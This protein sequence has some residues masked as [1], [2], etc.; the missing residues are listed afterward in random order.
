[1]QRE[2][3][4]EKNWEMSLLDKPLAVC[5]VKNEDGLLEELTL[6]VVSCGSCNF[7]NSRKANRNP[8]VRKKSSLVFTL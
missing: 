2:K 4:Y 7:P 1:M 3:I 6:C 8:V 5:S